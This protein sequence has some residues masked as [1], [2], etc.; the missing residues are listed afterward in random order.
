MM[1]TQAQGVRLASLPWG[2][3][4]EQEYREQLFKRV[5]ARV[6]ADRQEGCRSKRGFG[7]QRRKNEAPDVQY[8][9]RDWVYYDAFSLGAGAAFA[10]TLTF[11]VPQGGAKFLNATNL[12]GQGGQLPAGEILTL[13]S[14]RIYIANTTVPAD[15]Q[16]IINNVSVEFKVRNYPIFQCTPEFLPAGVGGVCLSTSQ[17]GVAPAGTA[18]ITSTTNGFPHQTAV[19]NFSVPY[20]LGSLE[21]FA[22]IFNPEVAFNMTAAAAVNPLGVGTTIKVYLEGEIDRLLVG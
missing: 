3:G 19:Y 8:A 6:R 11:A 4:N 16:N 17:L 5:A 7:Y 21:S 22:V 18:T 12:Q 1:N 13:K 10:K 15:L 14:I 9:H 20:K 2:P